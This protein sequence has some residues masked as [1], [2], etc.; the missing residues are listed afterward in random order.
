MN[1]L[2]FFAAWT[3]IATCLGF[4]QFVSFDCAVETTL[5]D[6]LALVVI[7]ILFGVFFLI[8]NFIWP[9]YPLHLFTPWIVVNLSLLGSVIKNW[10]S[11]APTRNNIISLALLIVVFLFAIVKIFMFVLHKTV[12]KKIIVPHNQ[13]ASDSLGRVSLQRSI[14]MDTIKDQF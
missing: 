14:T 4:A 7:G 10:K 12:L 8:E 3:S 6:T 9:K 11:S 2:G 13:R 5:A 1:G